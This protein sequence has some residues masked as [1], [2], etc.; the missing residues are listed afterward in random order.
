MDVQLRTI[1]RRMVRVLLRLIGG[2]NS[3]IKARRQAALEHRTDYRRWMDPGSYNPQSAARL[4]LAVEMLGGAEW[5]CDIGCANQDLRRLI[6]SNAICLPMDLMPWTEDTIVCDINLRSLPVDYVQLADLTFVV[7]VLE[8]LFDPAW[9]LSELAKS[10]EGIII[11]YN[12]AE[13]GT[14]RREE[15]GWVNDFTTEQFK[16]LIEAAGFRIEDTRLY[17]GYELIVKATNPTFAS[18]TKRQLK[19]A[20]FLGVDSQAM[21]AQ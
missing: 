19:R 5:V 6:P 16:A 2:T 17:R 9:F 15:N 3:E 20:Q 4:R 10:A 8:Y 11:S 18:A 12:V 13:L 14:I 1:V 7:G 21:P